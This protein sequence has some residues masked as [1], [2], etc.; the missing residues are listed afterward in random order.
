[1]QNYFSEEFLDDN[2][3]FTRLLDKIMLSNHY[4]FLDDKSIP[5]G[6]L[7]VSCEIEFPLNI[8]CSTNIS[9]LTKL[10]E[11]KN[12]IH[13]DSMIELK[14]VVKERA[15]LLRELNRISVRKMYHCD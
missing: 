1:L 11:F 3:T 9:I 6:L 5:Y 12:E 14:D 8:S 4:E 2:S 15:K 13:I 10:C 7:T